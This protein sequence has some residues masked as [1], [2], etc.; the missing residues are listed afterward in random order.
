MRHFLA[1]ALLLLVTLLYIVATALRQHHPVWPYVAAFAEAGM[2]GALADWFAVVALFRHPMGLPI[3]HTAVLARNQQ[4]LGDGLAEFL[5]RNFLG[6]AHVRSRLAQWDAAAWLADWLQKPENLRTLTQPLLATARFGFDA[7]DDARVRAF[8]TRNVRTA[9]QQVDVSASAASLLDALTAEQRHQELLDEILSQLGRLIESETAQQEIT[10][11]I[12]RELKALRY[13]ALDQAAAR[14]TTRKILRAVA[15]NLAEMGESPE[16]PLRQ[17]FDHTIH[18]WITRLKQDPQLQKRASQMRDHLLE[19]PALNTYLDKVWSDMLRWLAGDLARPESRT[20]QRLEASLSHLGRELQNNAEMRHWINA[21]VQEV[22]PQIIER[23][24]PAMRRYV[25]ERVGQWN[26]REL[27][28]EVESHLGRDLQYIRINGTLVG[29]LVGLI[30]H[31]V[32]QWVL[33]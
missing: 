30:I 31:T 21:Q 22:G 29:G 25:S 23:Y 14:L 13:L 1:P 32:T 3:P 15:R 27:I 9:L 20:R 24:R 5:D 28:E 18:D 8:F 12:A 16:H 10:Q 6:G 17:R 7:M 33:A 19:H 4:R 26:T 11:A 2:V